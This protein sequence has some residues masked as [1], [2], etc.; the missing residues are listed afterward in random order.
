M[1]RKSQAA[2]EFL[3]TYAWAFIVILIVVA[4]ISY[5]GI[6]RPQKILPDRCNFN[7][8]FDCQ[9]YTA[10]LAGNFNL[11][12]R[13]G[14]GQTITVTGISLSTEAATGLSG[15]TIA[16]PTLPYTNWASGNITDLTWSAC[17]FAGSGFARG[18]KAKIFVRM[19]YF[20]TKAGSVYAH[21]AEGE[22]FTTIT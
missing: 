15:C 4:A 6:L 13:N 16:T 17:N 22:I 8:G 20:D 14:L 1:Q 3:T 5:F 7:V 2:L 12:L 18:D 9:S 10:G 19:D 21:I 11:R